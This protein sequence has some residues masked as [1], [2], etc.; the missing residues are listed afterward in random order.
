MI[1]S[2][3]SPL[4]SR[5]L[6]LAPRGRDA[7]VI[8]TVLSQAR[9]S[10]VVCRSI[11]QL[12]ACL[13]EGAGLAFITEEALTDTDSG[14]LRAWLARQPPWSDFPLIVLA[15]KQLL[16]S[17]HARALREGLGNMVLLER[18]LN[19][20]SLV[21]AATSALRSRLRQYQA[22]RHL[23]E[24]DRVSLE[25]ERLYRA[26]RYALLEAARAKE[27]LTL[28]LDAAEL[29]TFHCPMPLGKIFWNVTCKSHFWLPPDA[30]VDFD[31]FY[32]RIH[33]D[34]RG[35][36]RQAIERAIW[37]REP[38]D[39]EY[40]TLSLQGQQRWLRAKGR[41]YYSEDGEPTRFDGITIDISSQ[42]TLEAEREQVVRAERAAR[43]EAETNSRI[44]DEF[45]A[46]LSHEL[47]TPLSAI[48]GWV[49]VLK[50]VSGES[51]DLKKGM[52][53][54]ER[55]ARL[56]SKLIDELLDMS[57]IIAGNLRLE[58]QPL[59]PAAGVEAVA[60]SLKP[61]ADAKGVEL[62]CRLDADAG[63]VLGDPDRLGQVMSN[64]LS[65]AL[66][67]TP[68]GGQVTLSMYA[69]DGELV[70]E[71]RDTGEGIDPSFLP[72]VFDRFRQGDGSTTRRHGGLGLGLAIVRHLVELHRGRVSAHSAGPGHGSCFRVVLPLIRASTAPELSLPTGSSTGAPAHT[73]DLS[74]LRIVVVD[75]EVDAR[76]VLA[77]ILSGYG[78]DIVPAESAEVALRELG[79]QPA[80]LLISDIGMPEMD[81]LQLLK[82]V[83]ARG[84]TVPAIALT[85]FARAEDAAKALQAGFE[86][87]LAK[88]VEPR[89]LL[90]SAAKVSR[91]M[92][93]G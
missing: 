23:E 84:Y 81:G 27:A 38:Y 52:D 59:M 89:I 87:H 16:R 76:E 86:L 83:R 48:L 15:P 63:P 37:E 70:L 7:D 68:R 46:T 41:A 8:L 25:N 24:Q 66:K 6:V 77:Q 34:D 57:R 74:G 44:K 85:A 1:H 14:D 9:M 26:E 47:R 21:S 61:M 31:V 64:L 17:A 55:N 90:E 60:A 36:T 22:R 5:A 51:A 49:Y 73:D 91:R 45:L 93:R 35:K 2:D 30:E 4:D 20:E 56:Q 58:T 29:G 10:A 78:A 42:K 12:C 72:H 62:V 69:A 80:D 32:A 33:P 53:A 88:P 18:P 75:D 19:A 67:F 79:R 82:Q 65:N 54:I 92:G 40:R 13:E 3:R 50:R 28:A 11:R 39:V 71:V 43:Q